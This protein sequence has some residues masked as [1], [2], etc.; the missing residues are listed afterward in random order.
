MHNS[1]DREEEANI[2]SC[3]FIAGVAGSA[4]PWGCS[5]KWC[6]H[7]CDT[8]RRWILKTLVVLQ[9]F[10]VS[11]NKACLFWCTS[12][13]WTKTHTH[14]LVS[15][16]KITTHSSN[17]F[18]FSVSFKWVHGTFEG[19]VIRCCCPMKVKAYTSGRKNLPHYHFHAAESSTK[20]VK[21][22]GVKPHCFFI[23]DGIWQD[24]GGFF[25][26]WTETSLVTLG[27]HPWRLSSFSQA[28]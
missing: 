13:E 1:R 10:W 25:F 2:D 15:I 27:R 12:Q 19:S 22:S 11:W 6:W 26:G 20:L 4:C 17:Q 24:T 21:A 28:G 9:L 18:A 5:Q 16:N 23:L 14:T 3:W 7:K 8:S